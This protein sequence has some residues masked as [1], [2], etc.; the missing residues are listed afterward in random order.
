MLADSRLHPRVV[1]SLE[2]KVGTHGDNTHARIIDISLGGVTIKGDG[3]LAQ[4]LA[5]ENSQGEGG[6]H[7]LSFDLPS[8]AFSKLCRLVHVRRLS[9]IEYE[10]GLKFLE[11][12]LN[13]VAAISDYI[14]NHV[15]RAG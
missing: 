13:D 15:R 11:L 9:Q 1:T 14:N 12:N 4:A 5:L 10:F 8:Q 7:Q 3:E 2:V 6:E